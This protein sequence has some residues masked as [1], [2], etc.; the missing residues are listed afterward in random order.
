MPPQ[1]A[2]RAVTA[3]SGREDIS[4]CVDVCVRCVSARHTREVGSR[5]SGAGADMAA[6]RAAH[7]RVTRV[8]FDQTSPSSLELVLELLPEFEPALRPDGS[9]ESRLGSDI[10]PWSLLGTPRGRGHVLDVELLNNHGAIAV[11]DFARCLV[12]EVVSDPRLASPQ[13]RNLVQR[14]L[15][16]PGSLAFAG[17]SPLPRRF[18]S[19][20][21]AGQAPKAFGL[22]GGQPRT[23]PQLAIGEGKC[24]G[25]SPVNSNGRPT[26]VAR[27]SHAPL[28]TEGYVPAQ[29]IANDRYMLDRPGGS[30]SP[31]KAHPSK[32]GKTDFAPP[33]TQ[34]PDADRSL[35]EPAVKSKALATRLAAKPRISGPAGE[36]GLEC[37]V[38]IPEGL[39]KNIGVRFLQPRKRCLGLRQLGGLRGKSETCPVHSPSSDPLFEGG[40]PE[41]ACGPCPSP[42]RPFLWRGR[43]KAKPVPGLFDHEHTFASSPDRS[44]SAEWRRPV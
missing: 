14:S 17:R 16:A 19:T 20:S 15:V 7:R 6:P 27:R 34:P 1:R 13:N 18:L 31:P 11:R 8:D 33:P 28:A 2:P 42:K 43:I 32:L 26:K 23:R 5:C 3:K 41:H 4:R 25:S 44:T 10:P 24:C 22:T 21:A 37:A 36:E 35:P 9:I 40:V 39:L 30:S 38:K 12:Q 29:G